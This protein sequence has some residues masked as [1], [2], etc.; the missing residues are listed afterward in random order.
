MFTRIDDFETCW[1]TEAA[2]T[3]RVLGAL[4]DAS[5]GQATAQQ[6]RTLGRIAWH[7]TV[8][9]PEMMG[10]TGLV[11]TGPEESA[12]VP[13]RAA[14]IVEAYSGASRALMGAIRSTWTDDSLAETD[15]MYGQRWQRGATLL[16]LV[17]H[18]AHHRGQMTVLMRQAGLRVPGVYGPAREDWSTMGMEPPAI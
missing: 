3:L 6:S 10:R 17:S 4:T 11:V 12:P 13:T 18:Q 16:A 15:D 1:K 14:D 9:I 7:I 2:G 5:L 8:T